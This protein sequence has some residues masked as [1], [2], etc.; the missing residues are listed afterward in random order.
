MVGDEHPGMEAAFAMDLAVMGGNAVSMGEKHY[1][2]RGRAG[3]VTGTMFMAGVACMATRF[4]LA[5]DHW[6]GKLNHDVTQLPE[7]VVG[8]LGGMPLLPLSDGRRRYTGGGYGNT[9]R[10]EP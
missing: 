5:S 4:I 2:S 9:M 8:R 1:E 7:K 3:W 10:D 6:P